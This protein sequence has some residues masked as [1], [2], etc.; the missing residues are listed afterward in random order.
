MTEQEMDMIEEMRQDAYEEE[1]MRKDLDYAKEKLG[2]A[3]IHSECEKLANELSNY[4]HDV[5]TADVIE[6][7]EEI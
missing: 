1:R 6:Y 7:L 5:S 4:G 2:I 3:D